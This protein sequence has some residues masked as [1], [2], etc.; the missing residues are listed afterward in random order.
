MRDERRHLGER[1]TINADINSTSPA[2]SDRNAVRMCGFLR[3]LLS[4]STSATERTEGGNEGEK[5]MTERRRG[6]GKANRVKNQ[7]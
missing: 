6:R 3:R 2:S 4:R 7:N 5:G 1:E